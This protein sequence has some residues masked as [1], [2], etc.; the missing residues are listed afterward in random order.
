MNSEADVIN[1]LKLEASK[2]GGRLWRN[3]VGATYTQQGN[4][5]RYGLANESSNQNK[6]IKSGDLIGIERVLITPE[7]VGTYLGQFWSVEGKTE[8]WRFNPKDERSH[9]QLAWINLINS[10][11]GKA[12]FSNGKSIINP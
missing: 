5:L 8:S 10:L 6:I 12:Y 9:A 3:N 7:M 11:G 1:L 2:R 4:F